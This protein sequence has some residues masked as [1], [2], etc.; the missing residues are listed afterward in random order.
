M[1]KK[2]L[3]IKTLSFLFNL[4]EIKIH[5]VL[6]VGSNDERISELIETIPLAIQYLLLNIVSIINHLVR[7]IGLLY[8]HFTDLL[9]G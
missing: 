2:L 7:R 4:K 9:I 6:S 8:Q 1:S 3:I 5:P